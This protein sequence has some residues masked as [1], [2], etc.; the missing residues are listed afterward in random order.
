MR[1]HPS[2]NS[3][4]RMTNTAV[5]TRNTTTCRRGMLNTSR[6]KAPIHVDFRLDCSTIFV[7][8]RARAHS[9]PC[10]FVLRPHRMAPFAASR[11]MRGVGLQQEPRT[12]CQ[13]SSES[14]T[15]LPQHT[16]GV[17]WAR[18]PAFEKVFRSMRHFRPAHIPPLLQNTPHLPLRF[19][20]P[21]PN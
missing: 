8:S 13:G 4:S 11:S 17:A 5:A 6:R 1:C 3:T 15:P 18:P 9:W 20:G 10:R 12:R 16:H 21:L 2:V 14:H 7:C 19:R